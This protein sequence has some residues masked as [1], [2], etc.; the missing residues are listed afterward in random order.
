[1]RWTTTTSPIGT[2][3]L[4]GDDT[5]LA[6]VWMEDQRHALP[7]DPS[8]TED[9]TPFAAALA[10]LAAYF[11][12]DLR[13]FDLPLAGAGTPF[14]QKVWAALR[15]IP[16]GTTT[17]YGVLAAAVGSPGAARAV[18]LANGRNP[19]SVV[20]PCHRVVGSSGALV[21]YGGGLDRKRWLLDHE[22]AVLARD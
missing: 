2:L 8:W 3:L 7:V 19:L 10:Q 6:G 15:D 1:M 22:A 21:G 16:Y 9:A 5:G 12:G 14:R 13:T 11:A 18:G 4:T 20:V 17:S